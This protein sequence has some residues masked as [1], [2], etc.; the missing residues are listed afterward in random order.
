MSIFPKYLLIIRKCSSPTIKFLI[1]SAGRLLSALKQFILY[2]LEPVVV[3]SVP[4]KD[5]LVYQNNSTSLGLKRKS[6]VTFL[7]KKEAYLKQPVTA[8]SRY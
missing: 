5:I 1:R 2:D 7:A 4:E 6:G 8:L 3:F